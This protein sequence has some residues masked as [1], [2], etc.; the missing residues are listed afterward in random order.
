MAAGAVKRSSS[1]LD[2]SDDAAKKPKVGAP[3]TLL[4]TDLLYKVISFSAPP[5][6]DGRL[7]QTCRVLNRRLE[8]KNTQVTALKPSPRYPD[9]PGWFEQRW[10]DPNPIKCV[11]KYPKLQELTIPNGSD[12]E[13]EA[14][15]LR[16]TREGNRNIRKLVLSSHLVSSKALT[17]LAIRC[18]HLEYLEASIFFSDDAISVLALRCP[19]IKT[20]KL[21]ALSAASIV[22]IA[23]HCR[24]LEHVA[25]I[26]AFEDTMGDAVSQLIGRC[27]RLRTLDIPQLPFETFA[28]IAETAPPDLALECLKIS[29]GCDASIQR[30]APKVPQLRSLEIDSKGPTVVADSALHALAIHCPRLESLKLAKSAITDAGL[31]ELAQN[32]HDLKDLCLAK[33]PGITD[34]SILALAKHCPKLKTLVLAQNQPLSDETVNLLLQLCKMLTLVRLNT[35]NEEAQELIEQQTWEN[36]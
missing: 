12:L 1:H 28:K 6:T 23:T 14:L 17:T 7:R 35:I 13:I 2:Q 32:C 11:E 33:S 9:A 30:L 5:V 18:P 10:T 26:A 29:E 8:G 3:L 31:I 15:A 22:S 27:P 21:R 4:P 36:I 19:G 34:T 24:D 25:F 16:L 20:L